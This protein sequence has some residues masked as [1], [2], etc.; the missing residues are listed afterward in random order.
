MR[1][2]IAQ[3]ARDIDLMRSG[4]GH[5]RAE[6]RQQHSEKASSTSASAG[7]SPILFQAP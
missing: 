6:L 4:N 5:R 7:T 1:D 3:L 2:L